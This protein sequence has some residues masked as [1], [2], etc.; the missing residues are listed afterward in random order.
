LDLVEGPT[1]SKTKKKKLYIEEEP[2]M[3]KHGLHHY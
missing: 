2:V 3:Q 1:S